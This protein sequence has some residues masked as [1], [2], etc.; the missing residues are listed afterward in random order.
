MINEELNFCPFLELFGNRWQDVPGCVTSYNS[1]TAWELD[2]ICTT[3]KYKNCTI[4][5]KYENN[6]N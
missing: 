3:E 5:I 4:Y 2:E 6:C 1:L